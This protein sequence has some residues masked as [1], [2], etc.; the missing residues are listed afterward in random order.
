RG[1]I[2][3]YSESTEQAIN[4]SNLSVLLEFCKYKII[5]TYD[6]VEQLKYKLKSL[7]AE[8]ND[9]QYNDKVE[10][11]IQVEESISQN[12]INYLIELEKSGKLNIVV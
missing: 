3:A 5:T 1:L 6:Y 9:I 2:D 11:I 12:V 4:T 8:I 7:F 10:L